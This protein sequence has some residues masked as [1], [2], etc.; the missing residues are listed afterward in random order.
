MDYS[1][2]SSYGV[3]D[4]KDYIHTLMSRKGT[5][6]NLKSNLRSQILKTARSDGYVGADPHQP[7]FTVNDRVAIAL[8]T[9]FMRSK[10][11]NT[12]L[13]I[14]LPAAGAKRDRDILS[15]SDLSDLLKLELSDKF[16]V[17]L[18]QRARKSD[19]GPAMNSIRT[20][21]DGTTGLSIADR[22]EMIDEAFAKPR[23]KQIDSDY[24]EEI[25]TAI[26]EQVERVNKKQH[27]D[28]MDYHRQMIR[29][30]ERLK[31]ERE[32]V[33][34]KD[35]CDQKVSHIRKETFEK[36]IGVEKRLVSDIHSRNDELERAGY[37]QR[38]QMLSELQR[39]QEKDAELSRRERQLLQ[40]SVE[41][42]AKEDS[43]KEI[44]KIQVESIIA[45][46][47]AENAAEKEKTILARSKAE[48]ILRQ[49]TD[50]QTS[51]E[52][53]KITISRL[54]GENT[55]YLAELTAERAA[56]SS[57]QRES[58]E[59]KAAR[60]Q[61]NEMRDELAKLR[62][63]EINS[64]TYQAQAR[65]VPSLRQTIH[66]LSAKC[67]DREKELARVKFHLE[68]IQ[69]TGVLPQS[70]LQEL[71]GSRSKD[72]SLISKARSRW[73]DL[74]GTKN[75]TSFLGD[76]Q[77]DRPSHPPTNIN[78]SPEVIPQHAPSVL[79]SKLPL[80]DEIVAI[81]ALNKDP[82][83]A[84][85]EDS[86]LQTP[87]D[88]TSELEE[89]VPSASVSQVSMRSVSKSF[90]PSRASSPRSSPIFYDRPVED[91]MD[92]GSKLSVTFW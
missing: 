42:E 43:V 57:V 26:Q 12:A 34:L 40:K 51:L 25:K 65:E 81:I 46:Y 50:Q 80:D 62:A 89:K 22:M 75:E 19:E 23:S 39:I 8:I 60:L 90:K 63:Q 36:G 47:E 52:E 64:G 32:I 59:L 76:R 54:R 2:D 27:S 86:K 18:I 14:F 35:E 20:Q 67:L 48:S 33:R 74:E 9:Q 16:L 58:G 49:V 87:R 29:Q 5:H 68:T 72:D 6:T 78:F 88:F 41:V 30:E 69:S 45:R 10:G 66:T 84:A 79:P 15:S 73:A 24:L 11:M 31:C 71:T 70:S 56:H 91:R 3:D 13:S 92:Q 53:D 83:D 37:A 1:T 61:I 4:F 7:G 28:E 77:T 17:D 82:E 55:K 85:P 21:T 44:V 38:Q